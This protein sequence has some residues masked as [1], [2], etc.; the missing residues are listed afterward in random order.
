RW[1]ALTAIAWSTCSSASRSATGSSS[2]TSCGRCTASRKLSA[3]TARE[4]ETSGG[5]AP[6]AHRFR[7]SPASWR[8]GGLLGEQLLQLP[9]LVHL[10]HDVAAADEFA[11]DVELRNGR[12]VGVVLD[13]LPDAGVGEH[14]DREELVDPAGVQHLHRHL[15]EPA[16]R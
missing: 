8:S 6:A 1:S 15:R 4:P 12:P 13:P 10:A 16:L 11:V 5:P 9:G 7:G 14:V 3:S 2:R